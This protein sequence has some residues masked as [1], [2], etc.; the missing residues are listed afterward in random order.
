MPRRRKAQEGQ[1]FKE[2]LGKANN[3]LKKTHILST[4][5]GLIP[6][7]TPYIG[8]IAKPV[9]VGLKSMGYGKRRPKKGGARKLIKV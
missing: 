1:G 3:W 5:A 6:Q 8:S 2:F 7:Q 9:A 4:V